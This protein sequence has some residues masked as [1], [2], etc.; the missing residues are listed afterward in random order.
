VVCNY[1]GT[2]KCTRWTCV[3]IILST[4]Y[5]SNVTPLLTINKQVGKLI[6]INNIYFIIIIIMTLCFRNSCSIYLIK[7][8]EIGSQWNY[9][10]ST[11]RYC[12]VEQVLSQCIER[13]NFHFKSFKLK[14][15]FMACEE[16]FVKG[17][18]CNT[19]S[20]DVNLCSIIC[21]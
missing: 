3:I 9:P 18:S 13:L 8:R 1:C 12:F 17:S 2:I 19:Y 15:W 5:S 10:M 7:Y 14:L 6:F 20:Y 16:I 11:S 21:N 4:D